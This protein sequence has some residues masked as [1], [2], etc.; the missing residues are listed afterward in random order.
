MRTFFS[1]F[2][3]DL[4]EVWSKYYI[5]NQTGRARLYGENIVI[6]NNAIHTVVFGDKDGADLNTSELFFIKTDYDGNLI[7]LKEIDIP[8]NAQSA[9]KVVASNDYFFISSYDRVIKKIMIHKFDL[10][11]NLIWSYRINEWSFDNFYRGKNMLAADANFFMV[12]GI[13]N[14]TKDGLFLKLPIESEPDLDDCIDF[15]KINPII[16]DVVNPFEGNNSL[17]QTTRIV[18]QNSTLKTADDETLLPTF[19]CGSPCNEI[20]SNGIDDDDDGMIDCFDPD[21]GCEECEDFYFQSCFT[22]TC[23]AQPDTQAFEMKPKWISGGTQTNFVPPTV[24]DLDGDGLPE[25][26]T[27]G[28]STA[29]SSPIIYVSSE[30]IIYSG[31][32][33]NKD[34][35][36]KFNFNLSGNGGN[37]LLA[38]LNRDGKGEIV[39]IDTDDNIRIF[40]DY[41]G[42]SIS[43]WNLISATKTGLRGAP[44]AADF[45]NDGIPEIYVGNEIF[46]FDQSFNS[47]SKLLEGTGAKGR[48]EITDR[49]IVPIAP[50]AADVLSVADCNGDPDCEG[51]ELICGPEVYSVDLS[52]ADGDGFELKLQRNADNFSGGLNMQDG[53]TG[54]ADMNLDGNLDVVVHGSWNGTFGTYIYNPSK[55]ELYIRVPSIKDNGVN[56][57]IG[58]VSIGN[59]FDDKQEGFSKDFPE[60][61][62]VCADWIYTIN[63]N[64]GSQIG[65]DGIWWSMPVTDPSAVTGA[66]S[67]DFNGDEISEIVYRDEENIKIM[68]GGGLP[69]PPGVDAER[70]WTKVSG[71]VL[72]IRLSQTWTMRERPK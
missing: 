69:F 46:G 35:P 55:S 70:N 68:Y 40:S 66:T 58:K 52:P 4:N 71:Q 59:V 45:N 61:I 54:V 53:A 63:L 9:P 42:S 41:N 12:P 25:I 51:L 27:I 56:G 18:T 49:A 38:D 60:V 37:P 21:C 26:V 2:D 13:Q 5:T 29:L 17:A 15:E 39:L 31:D 19:L 64:R 24:G 22:D 7:W 34:N 3:Q 50:I 62:T 1:F 6:K 67:F 57:S 48:R 72:S 11:G 33:S 43:E 47:F 20:C 65:S 36:L 30:V 16:T 14:A 23:I 44:N 32:G 10:S 8:G 28:N